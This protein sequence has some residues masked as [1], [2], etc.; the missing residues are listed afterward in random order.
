MFITQQYKITVECHAVLFVELKLRISTFRWP[1]HK[2]EDVTSEGDRGQAPA[3]EG[4]RDQDPG[5]AIK[6][7][8]PGPG[9]PIAAPG[10]RTAV[11][12][13]GQETVI[14]APGPETVVAAPGPGKAIAVVCLL[15]IA[16]HICPEHLWTI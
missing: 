1:G 16:Q 13:P 12:A 10:Q 8:A 2:R 3:K 6:L 11:A 14:A 9:K 5:T 4:D 15:I 7:D